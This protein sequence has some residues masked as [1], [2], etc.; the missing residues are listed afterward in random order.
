MPE[1]DGIEATRM[2]IDKYP[3][4]KFIVLSM[5][6]DEEYFY[7]VIQLG[8]KGFILKDSGIN[9]LENAMRKVITGENYFSQKSLRDIIVNLDN[10]KTETM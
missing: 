6:D 2:A 7:K 9:E 5:F 4:L 8:V 3:D 1:L 10:P